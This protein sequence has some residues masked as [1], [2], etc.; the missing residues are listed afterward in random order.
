MLKKIIKYFKYITD[1]EVLIVFDNA[2][3]LLCN[4]KKA[5]TALITQLHNDCKC[6]KFLITS[7]MIIGHLESVNE[8]IIRL[9]ELSLGYT[10]EL[11]LQRTRPIKDAEIYEFVK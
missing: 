6:I 11:F 3:D 2:E 5:F 9:D 1:K 4:D 8:K 10:V 7:R